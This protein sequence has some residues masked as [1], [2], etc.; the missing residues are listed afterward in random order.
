[1]YG[2]VHPTFWKRKDPTGREE[3]SG[4]QKLGEADDQRAAKGI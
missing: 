2:A 1:M 4:S 3:I